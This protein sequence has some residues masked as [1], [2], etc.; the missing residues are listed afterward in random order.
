MR[1]IVYGCS[2]GRTGGELARRRGGAIDLSVKRLVWVGLGV[3]VLLIVVFDNPWPRSGSRGPLPGPA[4]GVKMEVEVTK[5]PLG[6]T[7]P[8]MP[9]TVPATP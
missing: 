8:V 6:N 4:G 1:V 5:A 2:G 3:I 9:G 7:P